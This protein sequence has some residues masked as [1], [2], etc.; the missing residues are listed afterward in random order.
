MVRVKYEDL[1]FAF[2]FVSSD[3]TMDHEAYISLDTGT[4]YWVSDDEN[5]LPSDFETSDRYLPIPHKRDLDLGSHLAL[6]FAELELPRHY[7]RIQAIFGRRGAYSRFKDF[8]ASVG[9]LER[10]YDFESRA[11]KRALTE[12]CQANGIE[13][14]T[15]AER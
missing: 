15:A 7:D 11:T 5:E 4:I 3:A 8:L 6:R 10:W 14:V 2:D 9:A 1:E 13:V 12:W